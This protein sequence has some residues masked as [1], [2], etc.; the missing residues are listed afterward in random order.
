MTKGHMIKK[1]SKRL[2][3][4]KKYKIAKKVRE[5]NRKERK[6]AK[7]SGN[8]KLK[9]IRKDP[10]VPDCPFK[11]DV[12]KEAERRRKEAE[13]MKEKQKRKRLEELMKRRNIGQGGS[14]KDL[15]KNAEKKSKEFAQ[16]M[17]AE[18][19][20]TDVTTA[21][22]PSRNYI[23]EFKKVVDAADVVLEVLD[24]RDPIRSRCPQVEEA[25]ISCGTN[26]KL[27]LLLNKV[28]LVP[29]EVAE[30]WIKYLKNEFPT[31][32]FKASTQNQRNNLGRS[33]IA[34]S[35]ASED[36][37]Q[38]SQCL[39]AETLM[40]LLGNYCRSLDVKTAIRVGVVGFPNVGKSSIINSLKRMQAC[41]VGAVPGMTK[42]M[43]EVK[44]DKNIKM[45]DSPGIVMAS[46]V[47]PVERVLR[48]CTRLESS[49]V[50]ASLV[51]EH[52][53]RRSTR[54]QMMLQYSIPSFSD[55]TEFLMLIAQKMGRL[56]KGGIPDIE[57]AALKV[58]EDWNTGKIRYYTHPPEEHQLSHHLTAEI[59][60]SMT[61]A[62]NL[63]EVADLQTLTLEQLKGV[64][65]ARD[66]VV[67]SEGFTSGELDDAN[68]GICAKGDEDDDEEWTDEDEEE[69][70][71]M[72]DDVGD[73]ENPTEARTSKSD[74][75]VVEGPSSSVSKKS[76]LKKAKGKIVNEKL[77]EKAEQRKVTFQQ[78]TKD[79][80]CESGQANKALKKQFKKMK[81][82]KKKSD[83]VASGLASELDNAFKSLGNGPR[84]IGDDE[85]YDF[86]ILS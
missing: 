81:K 12:L 60:T 19:M 40:K 33:K 71:E 82:G 31:I 29:K 44:L 10:G 3:C 83:K 62:F 66:M 11:E 85:D 25:I 69:N 72:V 49:G 5:H 53:L 50:D 58:V 42:H 8:S 59:V 6:E 9:Q 55:A 67:D 51:V 46:S 15:V 30:K 28:D 7:K 47:D 68:L 21:R 77:A 32:A 26:K 76:V 56:K 27:V 74:T 80:D 65:A 23:K 63:D 52:I 13:A 84:Q 34:I 73:L 41:D 20:E 17:A 61:S 18:A 48:N 57:K 1:K 86:S 39:G 70:D 79:M 36:L 38:T 4:H 35:N 24:A 2:T 22:D 64:N 14:E 16:K 45:I 78:V 54:N 75:I 37:L 43:Q